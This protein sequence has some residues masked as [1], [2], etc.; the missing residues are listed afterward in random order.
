[1][2]A[3]ANTVSVS[4]YTITGN[5]SKSAISEPFEFEA[6]STF[7][8]II[9]N[10]ARRFGLAVV[11]D[12]EAAEEAGKP[13][14]ERVTFSNTEKVGGKLTQLAQERGIILSPT[15]NARVR[16]TKPKIEGRTVQAFISG[17]ESTTLAIVPN[18][19]A[20]ALFTSYRGYVP[21]SASAADPAEDLSLKG[22]KQPGIIQRLHSIVAPEAS[23]I[24]I[25]D[26][27]KGE[28]GRSY[29]EWFPV[30]VDAVGW[31]DRNGNLYQP[32]TLVTAKAPKV[33]LYNDITLFVRSVTLSKSENRK[34]ARLELVLPQAFSGEQV[35]IEI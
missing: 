20:E 8:D 31:R 10:I 17:D 14:E 16:V 4:G 11:I 1:M 27:V 34:A 6:G 18:Y 28:R 5:L 2:S 32:N 21:E 25:E 23:N 29:A 12:S 24:N 13:Y 26:A 9:T 22:I 7:A 15:F 35:E 3:E 30:S 33:M 19:N